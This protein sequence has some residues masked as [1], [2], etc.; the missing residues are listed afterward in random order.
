MNS[1]TIVSRIHF[2][3]SNGLRRMFQLQKI[4][5]TRIDNDIYST[6]ALSKSGIR[7]PEHVTED[8]A[9]SKEK[10]IDKFMTLISLSFKKIY[11]PTNNNLELHQTPVEH[12][13]II[14]QESTEELARECQ[15]LKRAKD[16]AYHKEKMLLCKQKEAGFQLNAEQVDWRDDTDDEPDDQELEAH[17]IY[18]THIQEVTPGDFGNGYLRKGQKSKPK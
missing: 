9:L 6:D 12:I 18:M 15:K 2:T 3:N 16:A 4:I 5:L 14:L 7:N 11:K 8:D 10:E 1:S 17:Y 13:R